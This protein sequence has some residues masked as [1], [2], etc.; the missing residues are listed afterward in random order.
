M[1][2]NEIAVF[3]DTKEL[4]PD[5]EKISSLSKLRPRHRHIIFNQ[6][7]QEGWDDPEAYVCYFDGITRSFTRIRQIVGR[8]L[9]QP[10]AQ[11]Y[12]R[13]ELNTATLIL[14]TPNEFYESV[15]EDLKVELRLYAP[16]DE[17]DRPPIRIKTRR[18]PLPAEH[19]QG[20]VGRSADTA[21]DVPRRTEHGA[22]GE[23]A[24]YRRRSGLAAG[25]P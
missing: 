12:S 11:R 6:S 14:N 3:T 13:E 2:A 25:G 21:Q 8:V 4:P 24:A 1:Q 19:A 20:R 9:R 22:T 10:G 23:E 17:P 15:L 16:E 18:T 7:L 5:A